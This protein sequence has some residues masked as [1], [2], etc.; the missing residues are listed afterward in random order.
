MPALVDDLQHRTFDFFAE[1]ADPSNGLI[2]DRWPSPSFS[3]IAAVGFGLT[4]YGV[5]VKRGW[6]TRQ[7]AARRTLLTLRF[8]DRAKQGDDAHG[9][10]G[11]H[12]FYYHFLDMPEG[13]RTATCELSS[14]D[15]AWLL[16]GVLFAQSY[17]DRN[18]TSEGEIRRLAERIYRRV[19][20][21]WMQ[22][23]KPLIGMGWKPE[24]GFIKSDWEGY[25]EALLVY[26]LA[27][28]SPTHPVQRGAYDAWTKTYNVSWG[29]FHGQTYLSF[30]PLFGHQFSHVWIDFRGIRDDWARGSGIDYFE[31]SRRAALAHRAYA[32]ANPMGWR[33]YGADIWGLTPSDGPADVALTI[34]G[35]KRQ[36]H[37]YTAR[38]V[39]R[40]Y[41]L[42]DGTIAPTAA[43]ASIAF[44]PELATR[45]IETMHARYGKAIYGRYGFFDAFNPTLTDTTVKLQHGHIV[46]GVWVDKDYLGLDQGPIVLMI[47]NHR[48]ELV[49][50][51]MRRNPHIVQGLKRAGFS[52]GWL[53][54][55]RG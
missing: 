55:A 29:E 36:F 9:V 43:A 19:D 12:G 41:I 2:P 14:V 18:T 17:F 47:E 20:W 50:K 16:A 1:R 54:G 51:V 52:G 27:L 10:A 7:E 37:T 6:M 11:N 13:T 25:N 49:W 15:T 21:T 30:P 26:V 24:S 3:S 53:R 23:R 48:S 32:I 31:N 34:D 4:S 28:A 8:F 45:A 44:A 35:V 38:G 22:V 42:D 46:D 33:G 5:G 39:G 40:E